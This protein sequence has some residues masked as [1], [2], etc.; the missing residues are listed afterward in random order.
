LTKG[1]YK[2]LVRK[3]KENALHLPT[4]PPLKISFLALPKHYHLPTPPP[5]KENRKQKGVTIDKLVIHK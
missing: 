4:P 3:I 2:N 5:K 1:N